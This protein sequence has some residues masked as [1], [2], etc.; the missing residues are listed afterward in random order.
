[1]SES[2]SPQQVALVEAADDTAV[3]ACPGA[4][5]TRAIVTRFVKRATEEPRKGVALLSFTNAAIEEAKARCIGRSELL[6]SPHFVGTFDGFINRFITSPIYA[7][8]EKRAP[9]FV[10]DWRELYGGRIGPDLMKGQP[11]A[12]DCFNFDDEGNAVLVLARVEEMYGRRAQAAAKREE[13]EERAGNAFKSFVAGGTF[14]CSASRWYAARALADPVTGPTVLGLLAAR[15]SELIVDEGQDCDGRE[16]AILG[17]LRSS[18]VRIVMVAD[19]DQAIYEFRDALPQAVREFAATMTAGKRLSGNYRSTAAICALTDSLR[20]GEETDAAVGPNAS[21]DL[22]VL[23]VPFDTPSSL[24]DKIIAQAEARGL[25]AADVVVLAH[26]RDDARSAAGLKKVGESGESGVAKIAEA[27]LILRSR[28]ASP[29]AKE[30]ARQ[31]IEEVLLGTREKLTIRSGLDRVCATAGIPRVWLRIAAG[32]L[33]ASHDPL[34]A[35][36]TDYAAAVRKFVGDLS[37]PGTTKSK[38]LASSLQAPKAEKWAAATF[39]DASDSLKADTIH[40]YKGQE[41]PAAVIILPKNLRKD[42]NG[43]TVL[44]HWEGGH[45]TEARRVLYVGVSRAER[46]VI[47]AVHTSHCEQLERIMTRDNVTYQLACE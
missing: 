10:E 6:K 14:A 11:L 18:G 27:S 38:S 19:F 35:E 30:G 17:A 29:R 26:K 44:D 4:G 21:C 40:S 41:S 42:E 15:F 1:V 23:I 9:S 33:A 13:L 39:A 45:D 47:L 32:R 5:K 46:L 3:A 25:E 20:Y 28:N 8:G 36:R 43:R 37:W 16:L 34:K 24:P 31:R 12:L 7:S 22:P 2:L